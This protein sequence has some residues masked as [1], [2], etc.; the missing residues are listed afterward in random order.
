MTDL[1]DLLAD[2][3]E[4]DDGADVDV[5]VDAGNDTVQQAEQASQSDES[6]A[7][8]VRSVISADVIAL[9]ARA[10]ALLNSIN[11][12]SL[13]TSVRSD[14]DAATQASNLL[15]LLDDAFSTLS[16]DVASG[17]EPRFP[18][19]TDL[20]AAPTEYVRIVGQ[21]AAI[22]SRLTGSDIYSDLQSG[23]AVGTGTGTEASSGTGT[24][25][26][27]G[28]ASAN[29][30]AATKNDPE[31]AAAVRSAVAG[32]LAPSVAMS[33]AVSAS[34]TRGRP[35][36]P[37]TLARVVELCAMAL[38]L[39]SLR[40]ALMGWLESAIDTTAPNL[41][42]LLGR[43]CAARIVANAGGLSLLART[44]ACNVP[45]IGKR[46]GDRD[47]DLSLAPLVRDCPE[48]V[49]KQALRQVA[50]KVVLAAR[51][52]LA[53]PRSAAAAAPTTT[54][55]AGGLGSARVGAGAT[56]GAG[57][58]AGDR[59][60]ALRE[61]LI[62]KLEKLAEPPELR[63]ARAL[64][65]PDDPA[66]SR[67]GGRKARKAKERYAVTEMQRLRN[68]MQF[69]VR[70]EEMELGDETEGLGMLGKSSTN[71]GAG[72]AAAGGVGAGRIRGPQIDP[73]TKARLPKEKRKGGQ[74]TG[75][76]A[77]MHDVA[78]GAGGEQGNVAQLAGSRKDALLAGTQSSFAF[79]SSQGIQLPQLDV[80]KVRAEQKQKHE[81]RWFKSGTFTQI[82]K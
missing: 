26:G 1:D 43:H 62:A 12:T 29:A 51:I 16:A 31:W 61:E 50:A 76:S 35:L 49:R 80:D 41:A 57:T 74:L 36:S 17:F 14:G 8:P 64:P 48:D 66:K 7:A 58:R 15:T 34:S 22:D 56:A 20:V 37:H 23:G 28:G 46:R 53:H 30:G 65:A 59:G 47:G 4:S 72:G 68:R 63:D 82:S 38:R 11:H 9:E 60:A 55:G 25:K 71:T 21:I 18:E 81:D 6:G 78:A 39:R 33:V 10:A 27:T 79:S 42:Q 5:D 24:G 45:A 2:L 54:T 75:W 73:R 40:D 69:G 52:D 3:A 19:L 70:E 32:T 13:A 44:P 77:L 67:R